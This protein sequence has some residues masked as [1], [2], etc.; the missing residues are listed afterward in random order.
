MLRKKVL[1]S[2]YRKL[3]Q[4][5]LLHLCRSLVGEGY[6]KYLPVARGLIIKCLMYSTASVKVLPEPA[7]A[8]YTNNSM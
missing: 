8:L 4:Y 2:R 5:A 6:G 1:P 7:E 3:C